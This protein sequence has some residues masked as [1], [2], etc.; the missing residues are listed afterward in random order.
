[1]GTLIPQNK[2]IKQSKDIKS[3]NKR[4]KKVN[5]MAAKKLLMEKGLVIGRE[6]KK[7]TEQFVTSDGVVIPA[8]P[9]R[10]II[11]VITSSCV[12]EKD[13]M[14][15][16]T[17]MDFKVTAEEYKQFTYMKQIIATFEFVVTDKGGTSKPV[18]LEL[19]G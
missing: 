4:L 11:H 8:Q 1:V 6:I 17:E 12:D 10:Y 16:I 7:A 3:K 14:Q 9:D 5:K 13:G 15:Y 18:K 19:K 2:D